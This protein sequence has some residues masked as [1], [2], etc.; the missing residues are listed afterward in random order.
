MKRLLLI[1]LLTILPLQLSWAMVATCCQHDKATQSSHF[2]HPQHEHETQHAEAEKQSDGNLKFHADCLNCHGMAASLVM[3]VIEAFP[4]NPM[5][6]T[7]AS[8]E[9]HLKSIS[10]SRPEKPQWVIAVPSGES[11]S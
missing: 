8:L 2:G 10:S 11:L 1:V 3:P 5:S 4:V 6:Q 9:S 7:Y